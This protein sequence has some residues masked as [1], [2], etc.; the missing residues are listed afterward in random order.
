MNSRPNDYSHQETISIPRM[1]SN[2]KLIKIRRSRYW[3][4]SF[5]IYSSELKRTKMIR[6]STKT[7][8]KKEAITFAKEFYEDL[9]VRKK[10]GDFSSDNTFSRYAKRLMKSQESRVRDK[11]YSEDQFKN[12][13]YKLNGEVLAFFGETNVEKINH[14]LL[15]DFLDIL[16]NKGLTV[17]SQKKYLTLIRKVLNVAVAD[18]VLKSLPKFPSGTRLKEVINPRPYF[19]PKQLKD[20]YES[21]R[22]YR[23]KALEEQKKYGKT[24]NQ[25]TVPR[26]FIEFY[27]LMVFLVHTFLRPSEFKLLQNKHIEVR[28]Y[29]DV[30]QLVISVPNAKTKVKRDSVSTD[31]ACEVYKDRIKKRYPKQDDYL[32]LNHK[33]TRNAIVDRFN[34]LLDIVLKDVGLTMD[35]YGQKHSLYSFRHTALCNQIVM[36]NGTN[37]YTLGLNARTSIEML[38]K[39]YLSHLRPQMDSFAK[40]LQTFQ[41]KSIK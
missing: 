34:E 13:G 25:N 9:I 31:V 14:S 27:D 18:D 33:P 16:T 39:H 24:H 6:K 23:D 21:A 15:N 10:L 35:K 41:V 1:P 2:L 5:S 26:D 30:D 20:V 4:V 17:N 40:E 12:D 11:T 8:S 29:S 22:K 36:N 28:K 3:M 37:L 38:E 32:F 7:E 19:S